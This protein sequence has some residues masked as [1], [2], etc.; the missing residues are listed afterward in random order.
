M[1][2][3]SRTEEYILSHLPKNQFH[4][5]LLTTF[6]F[7][8]NYFYHEV[9]SQL[10][11]ADIIN[12]NVLVDDA[13]LQHYLGTMTGYAQDSVKKVAI[14]G[15]PSK[16]GVFHPKLGL[17]FG[18]KEKGLLIIGSGNLTACGHGKN[19]EL[20]GAFHIEGPADPK[21]PLFKKAWEYLCGFKNQMGGISQHKIDWIEQHA[22]WIDHIPDSEDGQWVPLDGE[23]EALLLTNSNASIWKQFSGFLKNGQIDDVTVISP[24]FDGSG[25]TLAN[26]CNLAGDAEVHLIAQMNSCAFPKMGSFHIPKN[27][28]FHDWDSIQPEGP[29]RYV[30]AKLVYVK[31][32]EMNYCLIGSANLTSAGMGADT[33]EARNE[34]ASILL[35]TKKELLKE[36]LGLDDR[37]AIV[38]AKEIA[39]ECK[40]IEGRFSKTEKPLRVRSIDRYLTSLHIFM[41]QIPDPTDVEVRLFNGWEELIYAISMNVAQYSLQHACYKFGY[42]SDGEAFFA[43][44]YNAKTGD[45]VSNKVMVHDAKALLNTN[46]DPANKKLEKAIAQIE[47]GQ[48]D[49][50]SLLQYIDPEDIIDTKKASSGV[51]GSKEEKEAKQYDG[52]GKFLNYDQF[53]QQ[54]EKD[55]R[56]AAELHYRVGHTI[57]RI[58]E[59]VRLLLK[60]AAE[61]VADNRDEDEEAEKENVDTTEG[62][63]DDKVK[64]H[65]PVL[66][67]QK[68]SAFISNQK[69]LK[70]FLEK[71]IN[72]QAALLKK[73]AAPTKLDH[74][75]FAVVMHLLIDFFKKPVMVEDKETKK[76]H[77]RHLLD[78]HHDF[79]DNADYCRYIAE[80]VGQHSRLL[81]FS[82]DDDLNQYEKKVLD[83]VKKSAYWNAV[84]AISLATTGRELAKKEQTWIWELFMNLRHGYRLDDCSVRT[85]ASAY[86]SE[87]VNI[88]E[89]EDRDK[90]FSQIMA[91][92]ENAEASYQSFQQNNSFKKGVTEVGLHVYSDNFGFCHISSCESSSHG[93]KIELCRP[94]Y[95]PNV[96]L[97][98]FPIENKFISEMIDLKVLGNFA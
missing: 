40:S 66:P 49:L 2:K 34:E 84:F 60:R 42:S 22:G 41:D 1:A 35:R 85:Q 64:V 95:Q 28:I 70:R 38:S 96:E 43:Q 23:V 4:S 97:K 26:L 33:K 63:E 93:L 79:F 83:N 56:Q 78:C 77:R 98:D 19:H 18:D 47:G 91:F 17:F 6:S 94:G 46:P 12:T 31:T 92:W 89:T 8:F 53:T 51:G 88:V 24:F 45:A 58:L 52:S 62:R 72:T 90:L 32:T 27:L 74:S 54:A 7:D 16:T 68:Q 69:K 76:L 29:E 75:L 55:D 30:H 48:S 36:H 20:W 61:Q 14:T 37:G 87:L 82:K 71:Y 67:P 80:I 44:L 73:K 50:L 5:C 81:I 13:M 25:D 65:A 39:T 11:R 10:N 21:A 3:N 9:R 15:I 57:D 59:L 86:L